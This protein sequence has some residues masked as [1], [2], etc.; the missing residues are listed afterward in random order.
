MSEERQWKREAV[1]ERSSGGEEYVEAG[2][3]RENRV[4]KEKITVRTRGENGRDKQ[5]RSG[6]VKER[7]A[8]RDEQGQRELIEQRSSGR[9]E[10]WKRGAEE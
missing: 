9:E 2:R 8:E 7:S 10:Q 4:T 3:E 5:W 1:E 6:A